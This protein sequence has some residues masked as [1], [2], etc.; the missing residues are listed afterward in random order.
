MSVGEDVEKREPSCTVGGNADWETATMETWQF[1]KE[2]KM[3]LP[4]ASAI[5]LLNRYPK[6]PK[7]LIEKIYNFC[8]HRSI[9]YHG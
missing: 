6:K 3:E 5:P 2:L 8:V 1:P 4:Y 7:T 9:I